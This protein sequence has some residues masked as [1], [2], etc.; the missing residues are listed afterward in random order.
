MAGPLDAD[1]KTRTAA[2]YQ[3]NVD[4]PQGRSPLVEDV[5]RYD[6]QCEI[7]VFCIIIL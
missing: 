5:G 7:H 6:T 1:G 4:A 3:S 2:C